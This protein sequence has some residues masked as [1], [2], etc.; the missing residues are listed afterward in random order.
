[1]DSKLFTDETHLR[2]LRVNI[3]H[4]QERS[5]L[6]DVE[7]RVGD[8][9]LSCHKI[10]LCA[11]S[12]Y[13]EQKFSDGT[14]CNLNDDFEDI[15]PDELSSLVQYIYTG[16]ISIDGTNVK[17][18][19]WLSK[20]LHFNQLEDICMEF[21]LQHVEASNCIGLSKLA[22][23]SGH[24]E[25]AER[26]RECMLTKFGAVV[27]TEEFLKLPEDELT[28]YISDDLIEVPNEDS[29]FTAAVTWVQADHEAR[30]DSFVRIIQF[31]RL[32]YCST[33]F[34]G[35]VY[36][37]EPLMA[38][39]LCQRLLTD[40]LCIRQTPEHVHNVVKPRVLQMN[41]ILVV[42][43]G[44]F[45]DGSVNSSCWQLKEGFT[46][47]WEIL[48]EIPEPRTCKF[49]AC[50]THEGIMVTGGRRG[51]G[52]AAIRDCW[53]FE[54]TAKRWQALPGMCSTRCNHGLVCHQDSVYAVGG[55]DGNRLKSVEKFDMQSHLWS[56]IPPME[57]ALSGPQVISCGE[58][59]FV[60][61]GSDS[62]KTHNTSL[63]EFIPAQ[64]KWVSRARMPEPCEGGDAVSIGDTIYVVGGARKT[65]M[66]YR[67][68]TDEWTQL[69][70]PNMKHW[71]A[72]AVVW[73]GGIVVSGGFYS[74]LIEEY[75]PDEQTWS[76]WKLT[77]TEGL[78]D[79]CMLVAKR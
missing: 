17:H 50:P 2:E 31:I 25:L 64:N 41:K 63:Q 65:Y 60:L 7:L 9:S 76:K 53:I 46:K 15:S 36:H 11:A 28:D 58:S 61:S 3:K 19:F 6:T 20:E 12:S 67:L 62:D 70:R 45:Q 43:G 1:M 29:V 55:F 38:D 32:P 39:P 8:T 77:L 66:S 30:K 35:K 40:A 42:L 4:M 68:S 14:S 51:P 10:I 16:K 78:R 24:Q 18:F 21:M 26:T 34:L 57:K 59:I 79:H 72:P 22:Q 23:Q 74:A 33:D 48:T 71:L 13:F 52:G 49:S 37:A 54:T 73:S 44:T 56:R 27:T 69:P 5:H 75:N 47:S